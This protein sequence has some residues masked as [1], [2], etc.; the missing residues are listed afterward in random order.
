[1]SHRRPE[2][3]PA[4]LDNV[5]RTALRLAVDSVEPAA[6]GLD[7]IRAKI[8]TR[9]NARPARW[10][11]AAVA[12]LEPLLRL[13]A[14]ARLWLR[15]AGGA[16]ATRFRPEPGRSDLL[17]WLRPAAALATGLFVVASASWA[18]AALPSVITTQQGNSRHFSPGGGSGTSGGAGSS[19]SSPGGGT[20]TYGGGPGPL[21]SSSGS[22]PTCSATSP[23]PSQSSS[24]SASGSPSPSP[25]GGSGTPSTSPSPS[26]S[27]SGSPSTSASP[28]ASPSAG[29]TQSAAAS[30]T[31]SAA[32]QAS[33][34]G[35][36][37]QRAASG[38]TSPAPPKTRPYSSPC[39]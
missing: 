5:L 6:D 19:S 25:S 2:Q 23:K 29:P 15:R 1:M 4:S 14:P 24:S 16:V 8:A 17:G 20:T 9:Q 35:R 10:R 27:P 12:Y 11:L 13:L 31:A 33:H 22:S 38:Q 21:I 39:R 28:T 18:I 7:R 3:I 32:V 30:P 37:S 34:P 26:P 36:H